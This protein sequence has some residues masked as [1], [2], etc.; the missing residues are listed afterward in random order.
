M[1][2]GRPKIGAGHAAAMFRLGVHELGAAVTA[3]SNIAQPTEMGVFG[4]KTP[5]EIWADRQETAPETL[6]PL[7]DA[8][9]RARAAAQAETELEKGPEPEGPD[10]GE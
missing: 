3:E 2:E 1:A 5:G 4:T 9:A 10:I 8:R 6:S 7:E